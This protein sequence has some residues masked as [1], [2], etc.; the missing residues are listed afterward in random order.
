MT[1]ISVIQDLSI[2]A[3]NFY[4]TNSTAMSFPAVFPISSTQRV[5]L[6][7]IFY[8]TDNQL[9]DPRKYTDLQ[10]EVRTKDSFVQMGLNQEIIS[11]GIQLKTNYKVPDFYEPITLNDYTHNIYQLNPTVVSIPVVDTEYNTEIL[12]NNPLPITDFCAMVRLASNEAY[13]AVISKVVIRYNTGQESTFDND[14]NFTSYSNNK[15]Q[16]GLG[17]FDLPLDGLI[18]S[19][20][21]NF[22]KLIVYYSIPTL[23]TVGNY[24]LYYCLKYRST[25]TESRG[26]LTETTGEL[27]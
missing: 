24:K 12:L 26:H 5:S 17:S 19:G 2:K 18:P 13:S 14:T 8:T 25:I 9:L 15:N 4:N 23:A 11:I 20:L 7:L 1:T 16:N 27:I 6:P 3:R 10:I 21:Q 22:T